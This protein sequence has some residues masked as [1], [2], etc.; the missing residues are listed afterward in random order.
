[1]QPFSD[2]IEFTWAFLGI[3]GKKSHIL[4]KSQ[5]LKST[6]D[7]KL[8]YLI[9]DEQAFGKIICSAKALDETNLLTGKPCEFEIVPKG[10]FMMFTWIRQNEVNVI[11]RNVSSL[12]ILWLIEIKSAL[13]ASQK[14]HA[15]VLMSE[16]AKPSLPMCLM[17]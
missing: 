17:H 2:P 3:S 1:M 16:Y 9:K 12:Y 8:S 14:I 13:L 7:D 4:K 11:Q 5:E 10:K 6:A 15:A